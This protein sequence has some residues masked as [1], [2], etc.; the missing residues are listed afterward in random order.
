MDRR[1][2]IALVVIAAL[3]VLGIVLADSGADELAALL[4]VPA[5]LTVFNPLFW[6]ILGI[7]WLV[8]RNGSQQQQQQVVVVTG[9]PVDAAPRLRCPKCTGLSRADARFCGHCGAGLA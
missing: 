8:R 9:A 3:G 4:I 1:L 5:G 7:V 2:G 6:I